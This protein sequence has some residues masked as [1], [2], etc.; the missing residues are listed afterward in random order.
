MT[1]VDLSLLAPE[2]REKIFSFLPPDLQTLCL[3]GHILVSGDRTVSPPCQVECRFECSSK[4]A[5]AK[6]AAGE[7]EAEA[8]VM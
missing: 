7:E 3:T 5:E 2:L 8:L 6:A 4:A 1:I